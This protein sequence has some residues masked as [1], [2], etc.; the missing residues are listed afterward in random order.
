MNLSPLYVEAA[1]KELARRNE[2]RRIQALAEAKRRGIV[3]QEQEFPI[4]QKWLKI[5]SPEMTWDWPYLIFINQKVEEFLKSDKTG[6]ILTVPPRHGKSEDITVRLPAYLIEK[7]KST[8]IIVA[9]YSQTLS[10]KFSRKTRR[11][12]RTRMS[13]ST[14]RTAVDDWETEEGGG[15]YRSAGVGAGVTGMGANVIIVDDPV[16][17]RAE[18]DSPTYREKVWEWFCDDLSTRLEPGGKIIVIMTRWHEDDLAGRILTSEEAEDWILINLPALAEPG[19]PLGRKEG[20]ALCPDRY[21]V[22]ALMKLKRRLG[23]SFSALFQQRPQALEG[24]ILKAAWWKYYNPAAL[25]RFSRII[26]SWDTAF[27]AKEKNDYSVCTVWGEGENGYYLLDLWKDRVEYPALKRV[28]KSLGEKW[29]PHGVLIE[30]KASGQSLIQD[31]KFDTKL[32]IIGIPANVDK[33]VRANAVSS[34]VESGRVYL[35]EKAE[36]LPDFLIEAGNFP[37]GAHDDQVDSVTQALEYLRG[38][39]TATLENIVTRSGRKREET[40]R[41]Y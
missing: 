21:D 37:N 15:G 41:G 2:A 5:A 14:E 22:P 10:D 23:T 7:D 4:F 17:S 16:K 20:E 36:W 12:A 24:G 8:R 1:T 35:P 13:L 25:P 31:L 29:R 34:I 9:A 33:V 11:I 6:L 32:P 27:K 38:D 40:F 39:T 26:L 3:V 30:D 18:A 28:A 19:D